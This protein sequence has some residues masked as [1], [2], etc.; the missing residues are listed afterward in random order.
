VFAEGFEFFFPA[1]SHQMTYLATLLDR[2]LR[3]Q[4]Y[5]QNTRSVSSNPDAMPPPTGAPQLQRVSRSCVGRACSMRVILTSV[6]SCRIINPC[7]AK[8][9][10]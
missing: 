4:Q 8:Q 3:L 5:S 9:P 7:T 6:Y 2:R 1:V 10:C